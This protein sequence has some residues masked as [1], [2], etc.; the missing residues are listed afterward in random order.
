[1]E[2]IE[3]ASIGEYFNFLKEKNMKF[4]ED[5]IWNIFM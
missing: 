4:L 1:M 3:G 2:L 5:R